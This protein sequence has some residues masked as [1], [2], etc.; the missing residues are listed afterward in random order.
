M[1]IGKHLVDP[2]ISKKNLDLSIAALLKKVTINRDYWIPYL[3]GYSVEWEKHPTVFIDFRLPERIYCKASARG[4]PILV[5]VTRYLLIHECVEK[6]LMDDLGMH[7]ELAHN[8]A[9]AAERTAVEADGY[10][11]DAYT[12]GLIPWIQR[13]TFK[14]S[15]KE[16]PK[17]L[18]KRPYEQCKFSGLKKMA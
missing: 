14:P 8:L 2:A 6:C 12:D 3:A 4:K 11:W 17:N 13:V 5:D 1:S 10:S 18:D 15:E 16:S 9:T 7:Y